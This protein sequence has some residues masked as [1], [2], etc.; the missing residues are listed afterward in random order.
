MTC[1]GGFARSGLGDPDDVSAAQC[2][3]D[4][5]ALDARWL[6]IA[7]FADRREERAVKAHVTERNARTSNRRPIDA[8]L[9]ATSKV[10]DLGF[11]SEIDK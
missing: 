3:G 8:D 7:V 10:R 11:N 2:D 5:L 9:V 4:G 6:A 1:T